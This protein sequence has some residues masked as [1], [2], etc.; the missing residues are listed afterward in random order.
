MA[1]LKPMP[2]II[3]DQVKL[4]LWG[5]IWLGE[6]GDEVGKK[7][8]PR[9]KTITK[10][11][12]EYYKKV[13]NRF[14]KKQ[15]MDFCSQFIDK[16]VAEQIAI[17]LGDIEVKTCSNNSLM[18]VVKDSVE[19]G[20]PKVVGGVRTQNFDIAYRPDGVRIA[21]DSKTLNDEDSI[22][23]NW[24]NMINDL[25]AEATTVHT[26]FPYA[27]VLFIFLVP[28]PALKLQQQEDIIRTLERM[29]SRSSIQDENH[30]AES[31][32]LI[33]WDPDTGTIDNAVPDVN[34][35]LRIEKFSERI[36]KL[37]MERY[38]GLPPHDK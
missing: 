20:Q 27:L 2:P 7:K 10:D 34:S 29:N 30:L 35:S 17:M 4:K 37:Y 9:K 16:T 1:K 5:K 6:I 14:A 18:P 19:I 31:I 25:A 15:G 28:K 24:N 8:D 12:K 11:E 21:Y 36:Y 13:S 22:K 26:R 33:V 23:K 3:I 38:K 32:S